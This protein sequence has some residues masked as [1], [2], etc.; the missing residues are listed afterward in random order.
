MSQKRTV[1]LGDAEPNENTI[2]FHKGEMVDMIWPLKADAPKGKRARQRK[3][4]PHRRTGPWAR[5]AAM[6]KSYRTVEHV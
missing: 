1:R 2:L 3:V 5:G 6:A 4:V